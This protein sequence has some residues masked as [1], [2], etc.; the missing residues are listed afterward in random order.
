[1]D[2]ILTYKRVRTIKKPPHLAF[3]L[4]SAPFVSAQPLHLQYK[5]SNREHKYKIL[6]ASSTY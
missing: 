1:M 5:E 2:L 6:L 3:C 4:L